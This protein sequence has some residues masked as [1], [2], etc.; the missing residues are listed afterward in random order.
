MASVL[1]RLT[2]PT[3]PTGSAW[4]CAWH[5]TGSHLA[6]GHDANP[7]LTLYKKGTGET[8]SKLA[9]TISPVPPGTVYGCDWSG[10]YLAVAHSNGTYISIYKK[11]G[12][13]LQ[14]QLVDVGLTSPANGVAWN[15][16]GTHLAAV[17]G[18]TPYLHL[19]RRDGDNLTRL[20]NPTALSGEGRSCAW[21]GE[22]LAVAHTVTPFVSL[23][24][25]SGDTLTKSANPTTA[26]GAAYGCSWSGEHLAVGTWT[27]PFLALYKRSGSS[28][29]KL[30]NPAAVAGAVKGVSF[31][32]PNL[33]VVHNNTPFLSHYKLSGDSLPKQEAPIALP[34]GGLGCAWSANGAY[35]AT[36]SS[37]TSKVNWYSMPPLPTGMIAGVTSAAAGL[38]EGFIPVVGGIEVITGPPAAAIYGFHPPSGR[39]GQT[40]DAAGATLRGIFRWAWGDVSAATDAATGRILTYHDW[41]PAVNPYRD[42]KIY[43]LRLEK[44]GL[45]PLILP[46]TN[47]SVRSSIEGRQSSITVTIPDLSQVDAIAAHASGGNLVFAGGYVLAGVPRLN[48]ILTLPFTDAK[49]DEGTT[50]K[51]LTLTAKGPSPAGVA[52]SV[53]VAAIEYQSINGLK[54]LIRTPVNVNLLPGDSV[55]T[56]S[57]T[58]TAGEIVY[59]LGDGGESM[60]VTEA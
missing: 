42:A 24:S 59:A 32:G 35:L 40:A 14:R 3:D 28:L 29:S 36:A 53:T 18:I 57:A 12:D 11:T 17:N 39:I 49:P 44:P 25:L 54:R 2:P 34:S 41:T 47:I 38:I 50:N 6:V 10:D 5:P 23:Y 1:Q 48:D 60:T 13:N 30:T 20:A 8:L 43:Q 19:Y 9:G 45:P 27:T 7:Y 58:W 51:S 26:G 15:A 33:A 22:Y 4:S 37:L 21:S 52:K 31:S 56:T 46:A 55:V 16:A